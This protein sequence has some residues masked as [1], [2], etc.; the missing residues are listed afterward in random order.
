MRTYCGEINKNHIDKDVTLFG[1]VKKNRKLGNLL[2]L[3]LY[4][5][6]G[7]VQIVVS[8]NDNLFETFKT[9]SKESVV[10]V[11]GKV[12]L[13]KSPN[14]DLKTGQFEIIP[15]SIEVIS[16]SKN[17]PFVFEEGESVSEDIRLKYRYLDLRREE[18]KNKLLMRSKVLMDIRNFLVDNN[19]NEIETPIL[20]KPT[21]EGAKDYLVPTRNKIGLFYSLP[22]SPQT[23][24]QLLMLSGF[25]RYFQI[26]RCFR[27]EPLRSD[28]Q[29]EFTQLDIEMSFINEI[30]IQNIIESLMVKI[31]EKNMNIKLKTPFER[32]DYDYAMEHYGSDKPDLRFDLKLT[33]AN[34][35]FKN[36]N[37]KIFKSIVGA[38]KTIKYVLLPNIIITKNQISKLEKFA[39]DN[40]AK[41]LAWISFKDDEIIDGSIAKVIEHEIIK[42]ISNN[43]FIKKGSLLF[44]ADENDIVN[45]SLGAVRIEA[46]K[47]FDLIPNNEYKFVWI[48]NW[49]LYEYDAENNRFV[50][51]HHPFTSPTIECLDNFDV[52]RKNAKARSYDIVLNG[53]EIG[54]GSIR[55]H[56]RDIQNRMFKSLGLSEKEIKNKFGFLITAFEYGVPIHGGLAI[57]IDRLLMLMTNSKSIKDV[58]AFP[59][60]SSGVDLMLDSPSPLT[61]EELSELKLSIKK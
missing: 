37:F 11:E 59:K 20:C 29:P 44:I 12:L 28:R 51:A 47:M 22:Q 53:Y 13:R 60:N 14:K 36:T 18:V 19:F 54:G 7:I 40:G 2:F 21:P 26:A 52:D 6:S 1:W 24:K 8:E 46:A 10:K 58:I 15:K 3:D 49:P 4:D 56:N 38:N 33:L 42:E 55:I 50:A 34:K 30:E 41:G 25:D 32:M 31:F 27:D 48:V 23:F 39:K 57:G 43:E 5:I 61:P 35:Y 16:N 45:K 9:L 17:L